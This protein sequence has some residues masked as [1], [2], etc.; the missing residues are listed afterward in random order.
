MRRR[1]LVEWAEV[2]QATSVAWLMDP[3]GVAANLDQ[4]EPD[5]EWRDLRDDLVVTLIWTSLLKEFA[6]LLPLAMVG[7]LSSSLQF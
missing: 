4:H 1:H 6:W 7:C 5:L 2:T 3:D